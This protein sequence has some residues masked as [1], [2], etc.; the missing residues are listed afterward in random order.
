MKRGVF[1]FLLCFSFSF[2]AS[3]IKEVKEIEKVENEE[4][5][6]IDGSV[7]DFVVAENPSTPAVIKGSGCKGG[8]DE[9][10]LGDADGFLLASP[11]GDK[12]RWK[13]GVINPEAINVLFKTSKDAK[14]IEIEIGYFAGVYQ[15]RQLDIILDGK[16][17]Y[18]IKTPPGVYGS[19]DNTLKDVKLKIMFQPGIERPPYHI[20]R[21]YQIDWWGC[22]IIDGIRIRGKGIK[23]IDPETKKEISEKEIIK[24]IKARQPHL[25]DD[26]VLREGAIGF[27]FG[28]KISPCWDKKGFIRITPEDKYDGKKGYGWVDKGGGSKGGRWVCRRRCIKKGLCFWIF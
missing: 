5:I 1:I 6:L 9:G 28:T 12:R 7:P 2:S 22:S 13:G 15:T 24:R 8:I 3:W 18:S 14:N 25:P 23:L 11:R 27:D 16:R 4:Y 19:K 26:F 10:T 21:I 17:I 20:L